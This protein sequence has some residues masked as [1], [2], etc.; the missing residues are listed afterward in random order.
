MSSSHKV[1]LSK[2]AFWSCPNDDI[3]WLYPA[4][5]ILPQSQRTSPWQALCSYCSST[6]IMSECNPHVWREWIVQVSRS[7]LPT[8]VLLNNDLLKPFLLYSIYISHNKIIFCT[9]SAMF[10][11]F[12]DVCINCGNSRSNPASKLK[13]LVCRKVCNLMWAFLLPVSWHLTPF[14]LDKLCYCLFSLSLSSDNTCLSAPLPSSN[15]RSCAAD[16]T[17]FVW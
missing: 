9:M 1:L 5:W 14:L 7:I 6:P 17:K 4:W 10:D 15:L 12:T 13:W 8:K 3:L 16:Q 2:H 11:I